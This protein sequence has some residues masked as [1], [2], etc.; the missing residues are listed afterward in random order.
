ME[1]KI[2]KELKVNKGR[3]IN[4]G[5]ILPVRY[6]PDGLLLSVNRSY[7]VIEG[8]FS[9]CTI[10]KEYCIEINQEKTFSE[11]EWND[12]EN[13]YLKQLDYERQKNERLI[14]AV[15]SLT[16]AIKN[17]MEVSQKLDAFLVTLNA[18]D[19]EKSLS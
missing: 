5:Q 13:H 6:F 18:R 10:P 9:G 3:L 1:V 11:K 14:Q 16:A 2:I 15:A 7:Q 8:E 17:N 19:L 12:M 4:I